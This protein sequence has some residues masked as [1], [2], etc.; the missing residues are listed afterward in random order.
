[1]L[2]DEKEEAQSVHRSHSLSSGHASRFVTSRAIRHYL[3][4]SRGETLGGGGGGDDGPG[5]ND[6]GPK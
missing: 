4:L 2:H 3:P 1:M 5:E 6:L